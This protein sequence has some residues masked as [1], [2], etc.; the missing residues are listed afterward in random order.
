MYHLKHN[1][2]RNKIEYYI[3][4]ILLL[5]FLILN[6]FFI[7]KNLLT[8]FFFLNR[9]KKVFYL[10]GHPNYVAVSMYGTIFSD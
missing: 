1:N 9:V 8:N 6:I 5:Y 2:K 10:N 7:A 3:Y 4:L